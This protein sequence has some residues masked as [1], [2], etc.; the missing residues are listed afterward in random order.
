SWGGQAV[1]DEVREVEAWG[2]DFPGAAQP[3]VGSAAFTTGYEERQKVWTAG[4]FFQNVFDISNKYFLT[5]GVRVDGNS[6]FGEGF[7]LQVYPKVSGTWVISDEDFWSPGFGTIK[8][9][10]AYGQ[11]GRAPGAFDAVRTWD[12]AGF[13]GLPAFVPDNLGNPDLGPEVTA[14]WEFGFDGSWL[15]DRLAVGFTY[16]DQTTTDALMSVGSIPSE[17]FGGSQLENVGE[18]NNKGME[19]QMNAA[20]LQGTQWGVDVGLGVT[21]NKSKVVDLGG[22]AEFNDLNGRIMEGQPVPVMWDLRVANPDEIGPYVY[23]NDGQE[24]VIGPGMPTHYVTPNL[25][26]RTPGNIVLS[27]R[28]EYRGG[29][30]T[31]VNEISIRD[32]KSVV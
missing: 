12:A 3:T 1:G 14:E 30:Y 10:A 27:A 19:L 16:Y 11:S 24:V 15:S 20:L 22:V 21:T 31:E 17:G 2:E 32:R 25:S 13:A 7:G 26:I 5:A 18:I 23:E 29:H 6:A 4:F 8:L 9:R 28:G